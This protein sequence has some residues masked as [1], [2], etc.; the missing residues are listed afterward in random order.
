MFVAKS[1]QMTS[2]MYTILG[3]LKLLHVSNTLEKVIF[4][5]H[6]RIQKLILWLVHTLHKPLAIPPLGK[7]VTSLYCKESRAIMGPY[8]G[9]LKGGGLMN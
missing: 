6:V 5:L 9:F 4:V 8:W 7:G 3:Y 2:T 1:S